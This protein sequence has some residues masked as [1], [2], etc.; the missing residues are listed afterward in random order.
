MNDEL[1]FYYLVQMGA[2]RPEQDELKRKQ[3]MVDAL[4]EGGMTA[5]KGQMVGKHYVAPSITQYAAQL[6]QGYMANKGQGAVDKQASA[7]NAY[8]RG[9]LDQLRRK[10]RGETVMGDALD[11]AYF[12]TGSIAD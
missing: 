11:S 3:A 1:M 5:P 4:R 7:L 8:Q 6:G 2:M 10:R 12:G 9:T